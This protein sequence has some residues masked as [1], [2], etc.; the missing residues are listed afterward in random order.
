MHLTQLA[1]IARTTG[2]PVV[3]VDGWTTR[4]HGPMAAVRTIVCHHTAGAATGNMPSLDVITNGRPGLDGPLA[5]LGLARDGTVYVVA[6]GLAYH[7]GD[8]RD[9]DYA[10]A[11]SIG[12]EGEA[13]GVAPWPVVQLDAYAQLCAALAT[14]YSLKPARVLGHKEVCYPVGRKSDPNFD[15]AA[16]RITV[17]HAMEEFSMPTP[18]EIA[19]AVWAHPVGS[20]LE[21]DGQTR[22]TQAMA[23][24]RNYKRLAALASRPTVDIGELAAALVAALNALPPPVGGSTLTPDAVRQACEVAVRSVLGGLDAPPPGQ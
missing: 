16:F 3:E 6:A 9:P 8:V 12:I 15:M 20:T 14:V 4:G 1:D 22:T 21:A 23:S 5:N 7:A 13:T 10:N 2:Y 11:Y 24:Q 19:H 18:E 17:T